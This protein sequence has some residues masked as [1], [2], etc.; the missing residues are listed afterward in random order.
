MTRL[1]WHIE[2]VNRVIDTPVFM[3]RF[4]AVLCVAIFALALKHSLGG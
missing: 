2:R 3:R 1:Q 4:M